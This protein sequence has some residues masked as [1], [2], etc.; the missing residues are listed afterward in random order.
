MYPPG[1]SWASTTSAPPVPLIVNSRPPLALTKAAAVSRLGEHG[2]RFLFFTYP[3]S[4]RGRLLYPRYDGDL[5][6][7]SP[8]GDSHEEGAW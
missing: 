6:L 7:I 5:G 4:G 3:H 2:L 1:W 8:I